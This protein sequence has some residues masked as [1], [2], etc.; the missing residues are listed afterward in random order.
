MR[1][2]VKQLLTVVVV[3][4]QGRNSLSR[5]LTALS[6][7]TGVQ[8]L[9]IIVPYD[10]RSGSVSELQRDF[11]A[12]KFLRAEGTRTYAELRAVGVQNAQGDIVALTED[13]CTPNPDWCAQ[14]LRAHAAPYAAIGGAVDKVAPDTAL[15]WAIYLADYV[16]Y[17]NPVA[18]GPAH[19]LT[20]CNVTYK[21]SALESIAQVWR[22]EF[23]EPA[24]HG[25]LQ[26]RGQTLW[27][28]PDIVVRQQRNLRLGEALRDRYA[29][30]RLFGSGRAHSVSMQRRLIYLGSAI[31]L[32]MLLLG[33]VAGHVYRKRRGMASFMR[34]LPALVFLNTVWVWG[35]F[36][37]YLTGRPEHSLTPGKPA[38]ATDVS[39]SRQERLVHGIG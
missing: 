23:H 11:P 38:G 34:A 3:I 22:D 12:V 18:A 27:L 14:I 10:E 36:I 20:D 13:H 5:C 39:S 28:S 21:R 26:A 2:P 32:P 37:G 1:T 15:N 35:E 24:V 31:L 16:R 19:E 29:F 8:N 6:R 7:Q 33:R 30:G 9:E 4:L 17:M 25:A